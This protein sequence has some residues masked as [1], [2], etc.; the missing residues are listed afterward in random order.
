MALRVIDF[1][2]GWE[3][4]QQGIDRVVSFVDDN[5]VVRDEHT[6]LFSA[7][8]WMSIYETVYNLCTQKDPTYE[9]ELYRLYE[10]FLQHYI[11]TRVLPAI[12]GKSGEHLLRETVRR[13]RDYKFIMR[14]MI[15]FFLYLDQFFVGRYG[16]PTIRNAALIMFHN[17]V[18]EEMKGEIISTVLLLINADR[19][20]NPVDRALIKEVLEVTFDLQS[21]TLNVPYQTDFEPAL[22]DSSGAYYALKMANWLQNLPYPE[23]MLQVVECLNAEN[24]RAM[25]YLHPSTVPKLL[26]RTKLEIANPDRIDANC[27]AGKV[28]QLKLGGNS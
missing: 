6:R 13:W 5:G 4:I 10:D 17:L 1:H 15:R 18:Y 28:Q 19:D 9:K 12:R 11:N 2:A 22:L 3:K 26:E 21:D 23:Y 8:E 14:W 7:Y 27:L 16:R 25:Q 20:G 24:F